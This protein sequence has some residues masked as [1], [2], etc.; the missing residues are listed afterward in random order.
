LTYNT[1]TFLNQV[2]E[3]VNN[4]AVGQVITEPVGSSFGRI[5]IIGFT[6]IRTPAPTDLRRTSPWGA[7]TP[8]GQVLTFIAPGYVPCVPG[9]IGLPVIR[10]T[11]GA[12][13]IL[14]N[15]DNVAL[16]WTVTWSGVG[17]A[18]VAFAPA[19]VCT[20]VGGGPA[21]GVI[22]AVANVDPPTNRPEYTDVT[23]TQNRNGLMVVGRQGRVI[24]VDNPKWIFQR[25]QQNTTTYRVSQDIYPNNTTI[26]TG[27]EISPDG[28]GF[29]LTSK[30]YNMQ[31]SA[32]NAG[33]IE[34]VSD[35][36][37]K[38]LVTYFTSPIGYATYT[39]NESRVSGFPFGR[40]NEFGQEHY[41]FAWHPFSRYALFSVF[42]GFEKFDQEI[43]ADVGTLAATVVVPQPLRVR[44]Q[45]GNGATLADVITDAFGIERLAVDAD[46]DL[47]NTPAKP[48]F[49]EARQEIV[50]E[51]VDITG[52][53]FVTGG[54]S[55]WSSTDATRLFDK[56]Y[57]PTIVFTFDGV[58]Q[59]VITIPFKSPILLAR[60]LL[61]GIL[62]SGT[63]VEVQDVYGAYTT[64]GTAAGPVVAMDSDNFAPAPSL[65]LKLTLPATTTLT[66]L[67]LWK[68]IE[69][70]AATNLNPQVP[71]VF[72]DVGAVATGETRGPHNHLVPPLS[73][74]AGH[75]LEIGKDISDTVCVEATITG[76]GAETAIS[77]DMHWYFSEDNTTW[78]YF[79]TCQIRETPAAGNPSGY[80][81][82]GGSVTRMFAVPV[83]SYNK[84]VAM[85]FLN[86]DAATVTITPVHL[87]RQR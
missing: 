2:W 51:E 59:G 54:A 53:T 12:T 48:L 67:V 58:N 5:S 27:I 52:S 4:P 65:G 41:R 87:V 80:T 56:L 62:P 44:I 66:E 86:N 73:G 63:K 75:G 74:L 71:G 18:Q 81:I 46:L 35:A 8:Y 78:H 69:T 22:G 1:T 76:S 47:M 49:M 7:V 29:L 72:T 45:D 36:Y 38:N 77:V 82:A 17:A 83:K 60:A 15:Y 10:A 14:S 16:T 50:A 64:I 9:D 33:T 23:W 25:P 13:G 37:V 3:S 55:T 68:S 31:P 24:N 84:Y 26:H 61:T 6:E 42:G 20:I 79:A 43:F 21:T 30:T 57:T 11:A 28:L 85:S 34:S 19:D 70:K 32:G 40:L 39:P